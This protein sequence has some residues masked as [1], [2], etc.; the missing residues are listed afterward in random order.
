M[1]S[2]T[3]PEDYDL[4]TAIAAKRGGRRFSWT[5]PD[6]LAADQREVYEGILSRRGKFPEPYRAI[7]DSPG[8]AGD[9][10]QLAAN[11]WKCGLPTAIVEAIYLAVAAKQQCAYQWETHFPKA[12][13][14]GVTP[15]QVH[16]ILQ[17]QPLTPDGHLSAAIAFAEELQRDHKVSND[18]YDRV[19]RH[20][21][22]QGRADLVIAVSIATTIS[23][24]LN[25]QVA[26]D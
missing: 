13:A 7:L 23:L 22:Q 26:T 24:F 8:M 25:V 1:T 21:G 3:P 14:E 2:S 15:A 19:C 9:Y 18:T 12:L 16:Q 5:T 11:M 10:E 17:R 20:F 4:P 6:H